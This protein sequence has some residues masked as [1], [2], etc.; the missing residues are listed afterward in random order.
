MR[1]E[2]TFVS[3]VGAAVSK[4][5]VAPFPNSELTE[6]PRTLPALTVAKTLAPSYRLNGAAVNV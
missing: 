6:S 3:E 1:S 2:F 4:Y 5:K